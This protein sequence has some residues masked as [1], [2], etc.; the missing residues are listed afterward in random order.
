MNSG[1]VSVLLRQH[2]LAWR[3]ASHHLETLERDEC[4]WRPCDRG[5]HVTIDE[6]GNWLG[7]WPSHE[8]YDLGPPSIAWLLWHAGYWWSMVIDHSF[9]DGELSGEHIACPGKVEDI[10]SWLRDFHC[11]WTGRLNALDDRDLTS[12]ARTRWPYRDR[13]FGDVV[14]WVNLE[15]AK[16]AAEIGYARFLYATRASADPV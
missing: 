4:L 2:E 15:L 1:L 9:G 8:R 16:N 5:P 12:A 6:H 7:E 13:P 3:L 14:A 11:Q 10:V